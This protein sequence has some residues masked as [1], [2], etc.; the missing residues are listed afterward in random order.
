MGLYSVLLPQ[1][2]IPPGPE[3][4]TDTTNEAKTALGD[5]SPG[6]WRGRLERRGKA[7]GLCPWD[8]MHSSIYLTYRLQCYPGCPEFKPLA[9]VVCAHC[10]SLLSSLL[11]SP[12]GRVLMKYLLCLSCP[13]SSASYHVIHSAPAIVMAEGLLHRTYLP[14]TSS[15]SGLRQVALRA[16]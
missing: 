14:T 4:L 5:E 7:M 16:S 11:P 13:S 12:P 9:A 3:A 10:G 15:P 8:G 2:L 6:V 1:F